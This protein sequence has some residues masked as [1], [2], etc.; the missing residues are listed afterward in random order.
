VGLVL[1]F[2]LKGEGR[3]DWDNFGKLVSDALN[4]RAWNDDRQVRMA[5]VN[6]YSHSQEPRTE[7]EIYDLSLT[8]EAA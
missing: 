5:G 7:V 2:Y 1:A 3:G 6:I 4:G 8:V